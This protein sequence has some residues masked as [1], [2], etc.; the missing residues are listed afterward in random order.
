MQS[1]KK[2]SVSVVWFK[3][4]LRSSMNH[5][6]LQGAVSEWPVL[7]LYIVEPEYW[8][9]PDA[10]YR[11]YEFMAEC[12]AELRDDLAARGQPLI[13]RVG[14]ARDVHSTCLLLDGPLPVPT[15]PHAN[16]RRLLRA[17]NAGARVHELV[18]RVLLSRGLWRRGHQ[19]GALAA[20]AGW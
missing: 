15:G 12:L 20:G 13:F 14:A 17:S 4:D 7:P 19:H 18:G 6:L 3:R 11:H 9:Q 10:S 2:K 1:H 16:P 5:A 8:S